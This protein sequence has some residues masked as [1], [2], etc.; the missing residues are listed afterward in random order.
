MRPQRDV[1]KAK[2]VVISNIFSKLIERVSSGFKAMDRIRM[3]P[4]NG[5][6]NTRK[7]TNIRPDIEDAY[8]RG[9]ATIAMGAAAM[10]GN[11]Q[12][13]RDFFTRIGNHSAGADSHQILRSN[14]TPLQAALGDW[15]ARNERQAL[16][17]R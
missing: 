12:G 7:L 6:C 1:I 4:E 15:I 13:Q 14:Y 17:N 9:C 5:L 11:C 10:P 2:T 3:P 8:W 16:R